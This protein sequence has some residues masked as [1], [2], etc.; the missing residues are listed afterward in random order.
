MEFFEGDYFREEDYNNA[1]ANPDGVSETEEGE[2]VGAAD[3]VLEAEASE[4]DDDPL[5]YQLETALDVLR[6]IALYEALQ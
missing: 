5:D 1:L 3:E 6:G 4:D 2:T